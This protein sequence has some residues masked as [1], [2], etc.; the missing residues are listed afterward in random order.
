[1]QQLTY[2]PAENPSTDV[3]GNQ[4]IIYD[5][6]TQRQELDKRVL[7]ANTLKGNLNCPQSTYTSWLVTTIKETLKT[8]IKKL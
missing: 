8:P 4:Q 1:M 2:T 3:H 5:I 6:N 7:I